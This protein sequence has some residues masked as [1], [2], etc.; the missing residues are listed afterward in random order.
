[1]PQGAYC[2]VCG[3]LPPIFTCGFCWCRQYLLVQG[4]QA[5]PMN[6]MGSGQSVAAAIQAPA[7]APPNRIKDAFGEFLKG[8]AG[9]AGQYAARALG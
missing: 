9:E 3:I 7:G 6:A 4:A 2:S 8:F 5:P 1:M